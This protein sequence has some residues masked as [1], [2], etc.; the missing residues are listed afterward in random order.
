VN[1]AQRRQPLLEVSDLIAAG[2]PLP[3]QVLDAQGR[4]LLAE[5]QV[6]ASARQLEALFERGACVV[7]AEA[8]AVRQARAQAAA[9][10]APRPSAKRDPT[11]FDGWEQHLWAL[12]TLLRTMGRDP[13]QR[14]AIEA[15]ADVHMALVDRHPDAALFLCV[16]QDDRRFALYGLA[17]ALH[18]ATVVQLTGRVFGLPP[19]RVRTLVRAALTMNASIVE[20]QARMA[21]QT[22]PPGKRQMDEIRAHPLAS[23]QQLR[24]GGIIDAEW[25]ALVEHHHEQTGGGGYPHGL[26]QVD[27]LARLLRAADVF[28]AKISPRAL[29]APLLP[30]MA[31]RQ[32]FQEEAGSPLAAALIKA[33]GVYPPGDF[34]R[35]R[36]GDLAVV[37]HRATTGAAVQ[38]VAVLDARGKPVTQSPQR[39]TGVADHAIVGPVTE[40]AGLPR[41][42][43]EQV[44]GLVPP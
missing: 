41:V 3:F 1:D 8:E 16:R 24:D 36:N 21:E 11:L 43:P 9:A 33:V 38:A 37:T 34:V 22:D 18:T 13:A 17:H 32:L 12:D 42:L 23:A 15:R 31:A 19:E 26:E 44:Y 6:I 2:V 4:L 14:A 10:G 7:W 28:M 40:R 5:G 29:R 39:D 35:L 30:Q 25:L 20:L 27:D